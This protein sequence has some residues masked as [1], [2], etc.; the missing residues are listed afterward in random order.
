MLESRIGSTESFVLIRKYQM[1]TLIAIDMARTYL[2]TILTVAL[3]TVLM[4]VVPAIAVAE[5]PANPECW[6][7]VTSQRATTENDIGEH[8]SDQEEPRQGLGNLAGHPSDLGTIL[9][10]VD[11]LEA[12]QCP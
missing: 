6:G 7:T 3:S 1:V 8:S 11:G 9:A 5:Q 2:L 4:S 10:S 12:T